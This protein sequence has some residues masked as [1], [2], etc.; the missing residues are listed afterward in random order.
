[1]VIYGNSM[2]FWGYDG[3]FNGFLSTKWSLK[4][5]KV[6]DLSSIYAP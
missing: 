4:T 3:E 6:G 1:M 5:N 2:D